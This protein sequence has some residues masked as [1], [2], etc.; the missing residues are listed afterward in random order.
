ML[1]ISDDRIRFTDVFVRKLTLPA[2]KTDH[3]Q[4]G[5]DLPSVMTAHL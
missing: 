5:P 3:I 2:G 4:W 1:K